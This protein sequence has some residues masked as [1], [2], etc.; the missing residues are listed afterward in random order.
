MPVCRHCKSRISKFDK[1]RCP[2]CGELN[3]LEGV[4]S[5]TVEITGN[6]NISQDD[7]KDYKPKKRTV[8]LLLSCLLGWTGCQFF[9]LKY[10]KAG[11]I[12]L[13]ANIVILAGAFCAFFFGAKNTLLAVLI[14][15]LVIYTANIVLGIVTYLKSS[16]KDADGNLLR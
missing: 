15:L 14:P 13:A 5:D 7:F 9:Y 11:L 16:V 8:F 3:P 4:N 12:W 2:V 6:I 1:D 10:H